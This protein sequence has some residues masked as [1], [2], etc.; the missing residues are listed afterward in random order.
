MYYR[1]GRVKKP[2]FRRW[3]ESVATWMYDSGEGAKLS[4][5]G[6]TFN[7]LEQNVEVTVELRYPEQRFTNKAG[8]I[9]SKTMDI[10][11]FEKPLVDMLFLERMSDTHVYPNFRHDDKFITKLVST[12]VAYASSDPSLAVTIKLVGKSSK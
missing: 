9:S 12:K 8:I 4:E 11:N 1:D 2:E 3:E 7:P 6:K 10:T 5:L